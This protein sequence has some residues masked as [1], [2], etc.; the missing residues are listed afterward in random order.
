MGVLA[1]SVFQGFRGVVDPVSLKE[2]TLSG[3]LWSSVQGWGARVVGFVV[4]FL[5]A[6]LLGPEAIGLVALAGVFIAFAQIF[7]EQGFTEAIVQREELEPEHL[8][9]AFW[10]NI[11]LG[12]GLT[13]LS[14]VGAPL[15]AAVMSEPEL[16][17]IVRWL[18]LGF[19][20]SS[21]SSVQDA[22]MR[23][24]FAFKRL[25][26][27]HLLGIFVGGVLGIGMAFFGFGVWS[28]VAQELAYRLVST[29]MLWV[30]SDWRP[31]F[32]FQ[33]KHFG[34]LLSFEINILGSRILI[35]FGRRS[36][37]LLVGAFLGPTALGFYSLAYRLVYILTELFGKSVSSVAMSSF[38]RLQKDTSKLRQAFY[39][40]TRLGSLLAF[41]VFFGLV[42]VAP[43]II[44][45]FFGEQ[46]TQS[47]PVLRILAFVGVLQTI[48]M[49]EPVVIKASGK[50]SW[51]LGLAFVATV[52]TVVA[53]LIAVRFGIVAVAIAYLVRHYLLAPLNL[54]FVDKLVNLDFIKYFRQLWGP[55]A[56]ASLMTIV[57]W[58]S[59]QRLGL[60]ND[61]LT[62]TVH[63]L[64]GALTYTVTVWFLAPDLCRYVLGL[65]KHVHKPAQKGLE[66]P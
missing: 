7:V 55:F 5:L 59:E 21:L 26:I 34:D 54:Y 46:W 8:D 19:I 36:D 40:A 45:A 56:A 39:S 38:S 35:F 44:F 32:R 10:T 29:V 20:F 58:S 30:L 48:S 23:R 4:F 51:N 3:V 6:R 50:A 41:P 18:S 12:V 53:F 27:R 37:D 31:R 16:A 49:F 47:I 11:A 28:L 13:V 57:V 1:C 2:K 64:L 33:K 43:E 66:A 42:V 17:N 60:S 15:L 63:V 22:I 9:T 65:V 62:L 61:F 25:A 52:G 24:S 14:F